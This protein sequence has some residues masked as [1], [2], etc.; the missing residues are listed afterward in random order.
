LRTKKKII[1]ILVTLSFL[2]TMLVPFA[3][4]ALAI[5]DNHISRIVTIDDQWNGDTLVDLVIS[6]DGDYDTDFIDGDVFQLILPSDVNWNAGA[7]AVAGTGTAVIISDQIL[8]VTVA[9]A[10][11][12]AD[13]TITVDMDI[14]IDGATGDIAVQV[15]PMDAAV[16]GGSYVFA[17]V[18]G[19]SSIAK[20]LS[21]ETVG[22][23]GV[24]GDIRIEES[25]LGTLNEED[26]LVA[27]TDIQ[28]IKLE[29]PNHFD[30]DCQE[31]GIVDPDALVTLSGGFSGL[32][33]L[34]DL[35]ANPARVVDSGEYDVLVDGENLTL[36]FNV[37]GVVRSQRGIITVDTPIDADNDADYG[38]VEV[39]ITGTI[40]DDAD[41]IV[42]D[43][44]DFGV[45][46]TV[47]EV[48]EVKAGKFDQELATITIE[49]AV[50]GTL[51]QDRNITFEFPSWVK[52]TRATVDDTN[53]TVTPD[54][55][56]G[57]SNELDVNIAAASVGNEGTIDIDFEIS[58]EGNK[59][60]DIELTISGQ[61]A[62]LAETKLVVAKAVSL[63]S[64][65]SA[66]AK[67]IKIGVQAQEISD[68]TI[69]ENIKEAISEAPNGTITGQI[70]LTLPEGVKFAVKPTVEVL[71]GNLDI[72]EEGVALASSSDVDDRVTIPVDDSSSKISKIKVSGLK[73]TAD[74]TVPAGD[75]FL[76]VGGGAIIENQKANRTADID[77][78]EFDTGTAVKVAVGTIVT[79]A[80]GEVQNTAVFKIGEAKFTMNG[81]EVAMDVAPYLK[82]DRTYMPLRFV[83]KAAGVADTNIMW[84]E[85]DQSVVLIKGD[86]VVK[87][88]IGSNNMLINGISFAM[89]V[90]PELVDPGRTM[91]PVRWVAQALGC[92]VQ[93][94]EATQS[95]T[96]K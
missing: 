6:E 53:I 20:A 41:V 12:G 70:T 16:S 49:E 3:T 35:D 7:A 21:V 30:W 63:V 37:P 91:L 11:P 26:N 9:G 5:S 23:P 96:V 34:D 86:R 1:H 2:M 67:D 13:D 68:I 64:A 89:D 71:E 38:E 59:S 65:T 14:E 31:G 32:F 94:D 92:D 77:A 58:V 54:A 74:R 57:D 50:A 72:D 66:A 25:A 75:L 55:V 69:V 46:V 24:G 15:D 10:L 76:K 85:A 22:D 33:V 29:M 80:P 43:Y 90:A 44:A 62:G 73:V 79:P 56:L 19:D 39:S 40:A 78:G 42:A 52:I 83:A 95:V 51:I 28:Q 27:D 47:D 18:S 61:K 87:L 36:V 84:N 17:R 48:N 93:W 88:V 4:P 82:S 45:K 8:E 81:I 60:G